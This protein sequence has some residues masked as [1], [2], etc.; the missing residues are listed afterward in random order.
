MQTYAILFWKKTQKKFPRDNKQLE[1][2][3][4]YRVLTQ[5]GRCVIIR[6]RQKKELNMSQLQII[7]EQFQQLTS[8]QLKV[9][10]LQNLQNENLPYQINYQNL[11]DYYSSQ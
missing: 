7:Y 1:S 5:C 4:H 10:F 2:R 6:D 11:I 8:N 9:Q 3:P